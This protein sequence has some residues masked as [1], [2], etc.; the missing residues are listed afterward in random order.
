MDP[1]QA[2]L[3]EIHRNF[4]KCEVILKI[5]N[6]VYDMVIFAPKRKNCLKIIVF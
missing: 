4:R 2:I 1:I 5:L 3:L 6:K